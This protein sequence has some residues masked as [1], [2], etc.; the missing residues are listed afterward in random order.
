M[1]S[2]L[3]RGVKRGLDACC[4]ALVAPCAAMCAAEVALNAHAEVLFT[5]WAQA[6]ALVPGVPGVFLRRAFYRLTLD[7]CAPSFC[8]GF[9]AL[10]SHRHATVED[11]VYVGPY[12]IIG[13]SRLRR[14]CLIGSRASILSGGSLH[15]LSDDQRWMPTDLS[16]LRRIDIGEYAWIGESCVV[17][18]DVGR[19]AMVA[20]G[21]V[22]ASAVPPGIV[23]AGN[24]SRF[25]RRLTDATKEVT[26]VE[27]A[28]AIR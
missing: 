21:S 26:S 12:A 4:L 16:R 9:G 22:V 2:A 23:V 10:F 1:T 13:A 24:P 25:V 5:F 18:A 20:A 27:T 19:S 15:A 28:V 3:R 11:D 14:G 7:K 6:F 17:I 8:I